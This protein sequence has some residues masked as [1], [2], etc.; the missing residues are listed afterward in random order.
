MGQPAAYVHAEEGLYM[1]GP[2]RK[3]NAKPLVEDLRSGMRDEQIMEKYC[4][5]FGQFEKLLWRLLD[6]GAITEMEVYERTS[7]SESTVARAFTETREALQCAQ[8]QAAAK[9]GEIDPSAEVE[10]TE[11]VDLNDTTLTAMV[12]RFRRAW[13]NSTNNGSP[14]A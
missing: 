7:V 10:C 13:G 12:N 3:I 11:V 1:Q 8:Q 5:S 6:A 9:S 2:K 4:V 14:G